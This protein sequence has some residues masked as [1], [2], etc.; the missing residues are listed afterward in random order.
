MLLGVIVL[1]IFVDGKTHRHRHV[2]IALAED[3]I[4]LRE[5]TAYRQNATEMLAVR[6]ERVV[7]TLHHVHTLRQHLSHLLLL[8]RK[9]QNVVQAKH[10]VV[11]VANLV[12]LTGDGM[13]MQVMGVLVVTGENVNVSIVG[14]VLKQLQHQ[15][16]W[17]DHVILLVDFVVGEPQM[18]PVEQE[19]Y[20]MDNFVVIEH[21]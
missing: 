12:A 18:G 6:A 9:H 19:L 10:V 5:E 14:T 20:Q 1:P 7:M 11:H 15:L 13:T 8:L 17:P 3:T 16:L 4:Q 21:V 2:V